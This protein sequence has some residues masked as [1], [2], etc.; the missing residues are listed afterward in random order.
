MFSDID[1]FYKIKK[2]EF[3]RSRRENLN[4]SWVIRLP[5]IVPVVAG[6]VEGNAG[7]VYTSVTGAGEVTPEQI[8]DIFFAFCKHI[9]NIIYKKVNLPGC[10]LQKVTILLVCF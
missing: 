1:N 9:C 4:F 6:V 10:L 3:T 5:F 7:F 8:V 2:R